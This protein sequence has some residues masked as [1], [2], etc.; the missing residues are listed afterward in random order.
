M[1]FGHT[2]ARSSPQGES[3]LWRSFWEKLT[4]YA[5]L[6]PFANDLVAAYYC[7]LD[8]ET[9]HAARGALIAAVAYFV[10]PTDSIPDVIPALG[11]TDDVA[12]L[13]AAIKFVSG[14]I[15]AEHRQAAEMRLA[16]L[17]RFTGAG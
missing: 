10:V 9:P 14:Y 15:K 4:R 8:R 3:A 11:F 6:V 7:A 12:V 1:T 5:A 16:R 13:A 17:R 2:A